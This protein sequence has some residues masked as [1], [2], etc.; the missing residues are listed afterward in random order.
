L[1]GGGKRGGASKLSQV[2]GI[3]HHF[4]QEVTESL[5]PL[6]SPVEFRRVAQSERA[7]LEQPSLWLATLGAHAFL[8]WADFG[9]TPLPFPVLTRF[10]PKCFWTKEKAEF[11]IPSW[12]PMAH[13]F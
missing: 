5:F 10:L 4:E 11:T 2:H 9:A 12:V 8:T 3:P 7:K 13:H 1:T 6:F